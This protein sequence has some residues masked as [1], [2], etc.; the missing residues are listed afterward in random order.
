M[1]AYKLEILVIDFEDCGESGIRD[2]LSNCKYINPHVKS[3]KSVDIG[4]WHNDHP[5]NKRDTCEQAYK[6]YFP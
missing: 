3:V 6:Q 2:I 4:E 5:L 1:K